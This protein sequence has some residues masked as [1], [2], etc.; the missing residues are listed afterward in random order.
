MLELKPWASPRPKHFPGPFAAAKLKPG[1]PI[2]PTEFA[3][4]W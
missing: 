2:L 3:A 1:W 4:V